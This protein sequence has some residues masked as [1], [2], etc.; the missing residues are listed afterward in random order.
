MVN[1][2]CISEATIY[3][4]RLNKLYR[5]NLEEDAILQELDEL[6]AYF[7]KDRKKKESF[8]DFVIRKQLLNEEVA[9]A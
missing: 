5:E 8:G 7:K 2:I 1:T 3:G 6:F 9:P 4:L